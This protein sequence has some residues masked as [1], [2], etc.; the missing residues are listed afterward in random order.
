MSC[1]SNKLILKSQRLNPTDVYFLLSEFWFMA[2]LRTPSLSDPEGSLSTC[3]G[4]FPDPEDGKYVTSWSFTQAGFS[5]F[6]NPV[7]AIV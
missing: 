1:Y 3:V 4:G 2:V 6:F 5:P 7:I